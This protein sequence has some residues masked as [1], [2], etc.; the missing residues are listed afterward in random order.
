MKHTT[1][2]LIAFISLF[3]LAQVLGLYLLSMSIQEIVQT[4]PTSVVI[5]SNTSIGE[6]P[7]VEGYSSLIYIA[8]GIL[9]GTVALLLLAR[10]NK[11]GFWKVWYFLAAW[12]TMSISVGVLTGENLSWLAWIIAACLAII[13]IRYSHPLIHNLTEILMYTGIALLL[14]PILIVPVAIALLI[15]ISLYDAY[16]VW[17]SKHMIK[18]AEFTKKSNLFPGLSLSYIQK[19]DKTKIITNNIKSDKNL[20]DESTNTEKNRNESKSLKSDKSSEKSNES[21]EKPR[22]GILGGGDVVFP[23]L[24]SGAVFTHLIEI[25]NTKLT[26]L[27]YSSIISLGAAI[28]LTLLF[29]YGK[30]DRF[31]PAMPFITT[32]CLVGYGIMQLIMIL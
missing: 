2:V 19:K 28:A 21:S 32:G 29:I 10:F 11:M 4:G 13:K 17:K 27:A 23:M 9:I 26:A 14:A 1:N 7:Q 20:K 6:R 30:K 18:L 12:M 3:I 31:Y 22:I 16:A 15:L 8:I 5:Y 25:G 24:L